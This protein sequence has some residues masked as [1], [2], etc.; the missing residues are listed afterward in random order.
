MRTRDIACESSV[1]ASHLLICSLECQAETNNDVTTLLYHL[2]PYNYLR[3]KFL[4]QDIHR[5][6]AR[7][8]STTS[9]TSIGIN[10]PTHH[11]PTLFTQRTPLHFP[12]RN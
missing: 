10:Y 7:I 5:S 3:N 8:D 12:K 6:S 4:N 1:A 2:P 11:P 9:F